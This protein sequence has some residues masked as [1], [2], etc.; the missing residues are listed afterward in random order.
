VAGGR[1]SRGRSGGGAL[2]AATLA[3]GELRVVERPDPE[4]VAD[5][6]LVEVAGTGVN[7]A[8]LL[9][10]AGRHPAPAGWPSDIPGLE[11]AGT[12][13]ASGP[14]VRSLQPGARVL[15]REWLCAPAPQEVGLDEAGGVPE[16]FITAH[17]AMLVQAG[18]RPG[19]RVLIHGVG[20]GVGTAAV[21]LAKAI[22]ANTVGTSRTAAKLERARDLGLDRGVIAGEGMA[23]EMGE[24]DVVIDLVGGSYLECDIAVAATNARI[25]VVGLLAGPKTT[26]DLG[27]LLRQRISIAGTVLRARP[28]H[29]KAAV[30]VRFVREVLPLFATGALRPVTERVLPLDEA[31]AA[32]G[33]VESNETFGKVILA[34]G[35]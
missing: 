14:D 29:E 5:Q 3:D 6:V 23:D 2:R 16:V 19:E 10:R 17:D 21:Q 13:V 31:S 20:S 1:G 34:P 26:I 30:T 33:L 15:T 22:G 11:F 18:L 8:D 24:V 4:P 28:D 7:R 12:V 32:Y 27:R 25:V 9:Q 35:G